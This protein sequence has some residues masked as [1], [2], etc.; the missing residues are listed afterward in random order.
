M[1]ST[2][3]VQLFQMKAEGAVAPPGA[4]GIGLLGYPVYFLPFLGIW[5]L[6][7]VAAVLAPKLPL[8]KEWAYAGFFFAMTGAL[9]SHIAVGHP[10]VELLPSL[11]LLFLTVVSWY[12]RPAERKF[13]ST[14]P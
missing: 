12:S 9:Y 5:K 4:D 13:S 2:G 8:L 14:N 11:L 6:L 7:G 3:I 1:I 10:A